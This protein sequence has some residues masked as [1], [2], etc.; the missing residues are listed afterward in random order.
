MRTILALGFLICLSACGPSPNPNY[1]QFGDGHAIAMTDSTSANTIYRSELKYA[2]IVTVSRWEKHEKHKLPPTL[3]IVNEGHT[4]IYNGTTLQANGMWYGGS[5]VEIWIGD[6]REMP[7]LF[8]E[9]CHRYYFLYNHD[10]PRW[11]EWDTAGNGCYQ[12]IAASRK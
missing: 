7:S 2:A 4:M 3:I 9:L 5:V 11:P 12:E 8:H 1:I 6:Y 10:D